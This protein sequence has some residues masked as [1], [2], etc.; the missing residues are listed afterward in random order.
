MTI[1]Q[2]AY[3]RGL[4]DAFDLVSSQG[5]LDHAIEKLSSM[6]YR[7]ER[8]PVDMVVEIESHDQ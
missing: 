1:Q 3:L 7:Y 8:T 2:Q 5:Y 6:V 4:K